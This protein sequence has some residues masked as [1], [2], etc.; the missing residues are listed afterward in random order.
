MLFLDTRTSILVTRRVLGVIWPTLINTHCRDAAAAQQRHVVRVS[1]R[2]RCAPACGG[3]HA[4][5]TTTTT[6]TL[7][8]T[9]MHAEGHLLKW[10]KD[11]QRTC[12]NDQMSITWQQCIL[13]HDRRCLLH[14][15]QLTYLLHDLFI[16]HPR[17]RLLSHQSL[18]LLDSQV[19]NTSAISNVSRY[20]ESVKLEWAGQEV[21]VFQY[22]QLQILTEEI[23]D[24]Q[25]FN[26]FWL[27]NCPK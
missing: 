21:A 22:R 14:S 2:T 5:T 9:D 11:S 20:C 10:R 19:S 3:R 12:T 13:S 18:W 6:T 7:H 25:N 24:A 23:L 1:V 16:M 27:P 15:L 26:F 8:M 17:R 4:T